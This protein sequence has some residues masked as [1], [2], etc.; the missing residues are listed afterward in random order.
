[1]TSLNPNEFNSVGGMNH[2]PSVSISALMEGHIQSAHWIGH[3]P[4]LEV[5]VGN[6]VR[7]GLLSSA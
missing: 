1:M 7:G 3:I 5:I 4:L 2:H 6:Q